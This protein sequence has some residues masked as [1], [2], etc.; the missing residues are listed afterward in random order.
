[1][2]GEDVLVN[3]HPLRSVN[4]Y[5]P[6]HILPCLVMRLIENRF[7]VGNIGVLE[8]SLSF[9]A[10]RVHVLQMFQAQ[11]VKRAGKRNENGEGGTTGDI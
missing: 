11:R 5:K 3:A 7:I 1:M 9:W 6:T 8:N 4:K 10:R 2:W